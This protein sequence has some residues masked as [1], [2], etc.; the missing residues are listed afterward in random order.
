M[1]DDDCG[2]NMLAQ[3]AA[4]AQIFK[5]CNLVAHHPVGIHCRRT[6]VCVQCCCYC[7]PRMRKFSK[8]AIWWHTTLLAVCADLMMIGNPRCLCMF[9]SDG[10]CFVSV[11]V[12]CCCCCCCCCCCLSVSLCVS[13]C[14]SV[15][16]CV[17]LCLS[18]SL[19]V[20]L[21][22]SVLAATVSPSNV[23]GFVVFRLCFAHIRNVIF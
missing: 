14:L 15:S 8:F 4:L 18:V 20:S 16:F 2:Q 5:I 1:I 21:C 7:G 19:C 12:Y 17:S 9:V 13:L 23:M 10:V 11:C 22:L 6:A 3:W